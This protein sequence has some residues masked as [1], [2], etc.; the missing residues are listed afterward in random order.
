MLRVIGTRVCRARHPLNHNPEPGRRLVVVDDY[1]GGW[2]ALA[3]AAPPGAAWD[4]LVLGADVRWYCERHRVA[5]G[6]LR[7]C[8][9]LNPADAAPA[10]H[11]AVRDFLVPLVAGIPRLLRSDGR[12]LIE[13]LA[14]PDGNWWWYLETSEKSATRSPLVARLY[15]LALLRAVLDVKRHREL[16]VA[17]SDPALRTLLSRP[18]EGLPCTLV[19]PRGTAAGPRGWL[20]YWLQA[21]RHVLEL[22]ACH[23]VD[24][25]EGWRASLARDTAVLFF[26]FFP[27]WWA[28]PY[29]GEPADRFFPD[30]PVSHRDSPVLRAVWLTESLAGLWRRRREIGTALA[31]QRCVLLQRFVGLRSALGLLSVGGFLGARRFCRDCAKRLSATFAGFDV[32]PLVLADIRRSFTVGELFRDRLLARALRRLST[33]VQLSALVFRA[34]GQPCDNALGYGV[35]GRALSIG[36]WHLPIYRYYLPLHLGAGVAERGLSEPTALAPSLPQRMI[37]SG[38]A[39]A[40]ALL[41]QGYP[42]GRI[43]VCGAVR[44]PH[45]AAYRSAH[46]GREELRRRLDLPADVPIVFAATSVVRTDSEGLL[47]ALSEVLPGLG[48]FRLVVK[49]HPTLPLDDDF[50]GWVFTRL[51]HERAGLMPGKGSLYDYIAASDVMVVAGSTIAFEAMALGT[52]AI[53]FENPGAFS[54]SSLDDFGDAC[55]VTHTAAELR[56]ALQL[57]LS[58]TPEAEA[59]RRAAISAVNRAFA[60]VDDNALPHMLRALEEVGAF[61][62]GVQH[63]PVRA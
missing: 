54:A 3:R 59:R 14:S 24:R 30:L 61:R 8:V 33:Q 51:G 10:A 45:L 6:Q 50:L 1:D 7:D 60:F 5:L 52:A 13:S 23:A 4:V 57:T 49:L 9:F 56:S 16:W 39:G 28:A 40:E 15:G 35:A 44:Q 34:E 58:N 37:V 42:A 32:L 21:W 43:G 53:A 20:W 55:V 41:R 22:A 63:A 25:L 26:S 38:R 46:P 62:P 12:P 17:V 27:H 11:E 31:Q 48:E 29:S 18:Q 19:V 47:S 2:I 36:F